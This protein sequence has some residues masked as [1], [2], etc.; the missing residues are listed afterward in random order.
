M[1]AFAGTVSLRYVRRF[2]ATVAAIAVLCAVTLLYL[3]P[4]FVVDIANGLWMCI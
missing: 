1:N 4:R 3:E 2:A